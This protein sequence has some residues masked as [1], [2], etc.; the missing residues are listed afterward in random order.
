MFN[1]KKKTSIFI[2]R[3]QPFHQG[4]EKIFLKTLKNTGQVAILVMNSHN[5]GKKNPLSFQQV[6]KKIND[7]LKRYKKKYIII[8]IPVV[9]EFI[10]GRKVGYKVKK[11]IDKKTTKISATKIRANA[12]KKYGINYIKALSKIKVNDLKKI[13][14]K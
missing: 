11:L 4:H 10:Y 7:R 8:K 6:K 1:W 9:G 13:E 5:V 3:F 2:G 12:K 14:N